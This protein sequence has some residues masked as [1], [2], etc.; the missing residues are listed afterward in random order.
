MTGN[1]GG[2][3]EHFTA[4]MLSLTDRNMSLGTKKVSQTVPTLS[5]QIHACKRHL[6]HVAQ[7]YMLLHIPETWDP[8][9]PII[10]F[11]WF[12]AI[13]IHLLIKFGVDC[14]SCYIGSRRPS[15]CMLTWL[16]WY[17]ARQF[18]LSLLIHDHQQ[19]V[20]TELTHGLENHCLDSNPQHSLMLTQNY[21]S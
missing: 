15:F 14:T 8:N 10:A 7:S 13:F 6:I 5:S 20:M 9:S 18:C 3:R 19:D 1:P 21:V 17:F 2:T 4:H 11:S 12:L 16:W